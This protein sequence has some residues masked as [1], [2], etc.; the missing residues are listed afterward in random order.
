MRVT[1][2]KLVDRPVEFID[3]ACEFH[4]SLVEIVIE[5]PDV[6]ERK[7]TELLSLRVGSWQFQKCSSRL[8]RRT[9]IYSSHKFSTASK[10]NF[11]M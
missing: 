3:M 11:S 7:K 6:F 10:P 1:D 2:M 8:S 5:L 9:L 4:A